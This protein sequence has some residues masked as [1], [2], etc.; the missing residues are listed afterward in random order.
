MSIERL[1]KKTYDP[2]ADPEAH[3]KD[4][5]ARQV[6]KPTAEELSQV[7]DGLNTL[8]EW[9]REGSLEFHHSLKDKF[10][11][12]LVS[13]WKQKLVEQG[14]NEFAERLQYLLATFESITDAG[15]SFPVLQQKLAQW[16]WTAS[17]L[18]TGYA[19]LDELKRELDLDYK[20]WFAKVLHGQTGGE[21]L[22]ESAQA[23]WKSN[24]SQA[25]LEEAIILANETEYLSRNRELNRLNVMLV[26]YKETAD[27]V[28]KTS[29]T[30]G[31]LTHQF[32]SELNS[33]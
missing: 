8:L 3:R 4:F 25:R 1:L 26:W 9:Q 17:D 24:T 15:Q 16:G 18:I 29:F 7:R 22:A 6:Y 31:R 14:N 32:N 5:Y 20:I 13:K 19:V 27:L 23:R 12:D 30:N 33:K 28:S 21:N 10:Y 2:F 11:I